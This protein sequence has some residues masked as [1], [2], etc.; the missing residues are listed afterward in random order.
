MSKR[1]IAIRVIGGALAVIVLAWFANANAGER[2]DIDFLLF[3]VR[4]VSL[5]VVLYGAVIVGMLLVLL[6]GL[7]TDLRARRQIQRYKRIAGDLAGDG[8]PAQGAKG[9]KSSKVEEKV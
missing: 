2:V 9:A 6:V 8:D 4:D 5:S 7:R 3:A 1:D